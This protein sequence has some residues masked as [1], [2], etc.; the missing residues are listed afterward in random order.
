MFSFT[1][2]PIVDTRLKS[3]LLL[4]R[5]APFQ[6]SIVNYETME[7]SSFEIS[8]DQV[9]QYYSGASVTQC[10]LLLFVVVLLLL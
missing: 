9:N 8:Q 5:E 4:G 2:S 7:T 3:F 1:A 6:I 10:S